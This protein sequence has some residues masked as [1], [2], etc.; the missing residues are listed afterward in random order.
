[1]E[2]ASLT[3]DLLRRYDRA[4]PRYTSYPAAPHFSAA[5]DERALRDVAHHVMTLADAED[6]PG[7]GAAVRVRL[8]D[9]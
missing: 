1:M 5:F 4:G 9:S 2:M 7:H 3:A 6:L 8:G